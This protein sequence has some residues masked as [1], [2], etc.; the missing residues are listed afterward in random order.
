MN[1][2]F[3]S[4]ELGKATWTEPRNLTEMPIVIYVT[5]GPRTLIFPFELS[6]L[7]IIILIGLTYDQKN[8][9]SELLISHTWSILGKTAT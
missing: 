8:G 7:E 6:L 1:T 5:V 9:S 3:N 2:G 4:S